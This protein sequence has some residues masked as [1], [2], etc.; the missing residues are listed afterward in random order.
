MTAT[1]NGSPETRN[2][3]VSA[4]ITILSPDNHFNPELDQSSYSG[5]IDE[6]V[7]AGAIVV[8]FTVIDEDPA[9]DAAGIGALMLLGSDSQYFTAEMTGTNTGVLR[10]K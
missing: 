3:S 10:T 6:G 5:D 4:I 2:T 1:D 7:P 8:N 9:P